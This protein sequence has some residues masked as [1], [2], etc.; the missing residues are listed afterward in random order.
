LDY[1]FLENIDEES[2]LFDVD[3]TAKIFE[4]FFDETYLTFE[5][6]DNNLTI[7]LVT[8]NLAKKFEEMSYKNKVIVL[9]SG[10]LHSEQVLKDVF[11]LNNFKI[12]EA[13][14]EQQ[15][16]ID[17]VETGMEFDCRYQNLSNENG[18]EHFLKALDM[19]VKVAKKPILV[20]VSAFKD[21]PDQYE[22]ETYSLSNLISRD[23]F[24][25]IQDEDKE[26]RIIEEFKKGQIDI[27]FTTRCAR[28]VDF[29]GD[30][31]NSIIFTKYP[32]PNPE[33][34]FWKILKETNPNQYWEFYKDKAKR[35]LLQRIYRGLRFKGDH[36]YLLSPDTRVLEFFRT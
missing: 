11:G 20:Q 7:N 32:N 25:E 27:L 4:S 1:D 8:T 33:D 9:M 13:E 31:C 14:S 36:V 23:K 3:E 30:E 17:I 16:K 19:C 26:G 15:G 18:R 12:I 2:Y 35:D 21:L 10:T 5:K 24:K 28:G 34:A 22:I 29:P 6:K